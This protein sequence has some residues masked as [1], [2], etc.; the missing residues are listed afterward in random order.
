MGLPEKLIKETKVKM[1]ISA[2]SSTKNETQ[3]YETVLH[4]DLLHSKRQ[5]IFLISY[6]FV[7]DTGMKTYSENQN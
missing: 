6:A 2:M 4:C 5:V 7:P 3:V 1:Y